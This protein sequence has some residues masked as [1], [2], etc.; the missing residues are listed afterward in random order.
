MSQI[1]RKNAYVC[2][3]GFGGLPGLP[4]PGCGHFMVTVD[5]DEGVTPFAMPCEHCGATAYSRMYRVALNIEPTHEWYKP[6][7]IDA[8]PQWAR[9]HISQG[10]LMLRAI[11]G[12]G[13]WLHP[14]ALILPQLIAT[15]CRSAR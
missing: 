2:D 4:R 11:E 12:R 5:R 1:G 6:E 7:S 8:E 14:N 15:A 10:G 3:G 13:Q 9:H